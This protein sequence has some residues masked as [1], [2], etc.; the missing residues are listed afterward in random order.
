MDNELDLYEQAEQLELQYLKL[1][2]EGAE[3]KTLKELEKKYFE[4]LEKIRSDELQEEIEWAAILIEDGAVEPNVFNTFEWVNTCVEQLDN[5]L[6]RGTHLADT[7]PTNQDWKIPAF[8][9][10]EAI[11]D[12]DWKGL[13]TLACYG[14]YR[15]E[16]KI[17]D[18]EYRENGVYFNPLE[19][20]LSTIRCGG[21]PNP[22][23]LLSL[24]KAFELYFSRQGDL[25]L[26]EVFFGK[27]TKLG[28]Y[29]KRR[30]ENFKGI[31]FKQFEDSVRRTRQLNR[32]GRENI[33]AM[34][35]DKLAEI[36][37]EQKILDEPESG[38]FL[39]DTDSFLRR[40]R[41]WK[42]RQGISR[43]N[44]DGHVE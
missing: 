34:T 5:P 9:T 35:I 15:S 7:Y 39:E 43:K 12:D 25:S 38:L 31:D 1:E 11:F 28:N 41:R 33:D 40:Y 29:A 36:F 8:A 32:G 2:A 18:F 37:I 44:R 30:N 22:E 10:N 27:P 42:H 3:I 24:A 13:D 20:L 6:E 4:L 26:E 17:E 14:K 21:M 23:L 19:Y 16:N